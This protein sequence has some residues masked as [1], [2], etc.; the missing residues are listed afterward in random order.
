MSSLILMPVDNLSRIVIRGEGDAS[1]APTTRPYAVELQR[2]RRVAVGLANC[3]GEDGL[4]VTVDGKECALVAQIGW[5][6]RAKLPLLLSDIGPQL[7]HFD[8]VDL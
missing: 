2:P 5:I 6:A 3:I 1:A 4:G 8:E 7:I